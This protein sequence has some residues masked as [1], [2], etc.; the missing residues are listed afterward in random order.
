MEPAWDFFLPPCCQN[1]AN[2][3]SL[4]DP[5][6]FSHR[7]L[8][9]S[10]LIVVMGRRSETFLK[11]PREAAAGSQ[12]LNISPKDKL[13]CCLC[14]QPLKLSTLGMHF[15]RCR[16]NGGG[17][18]RPN[19][20]RK[21]KA[22]EDKVIEAKQSSV[23]PSADD[24]DDDNDD[25]LDLS[26]LDPLKGFVPRPEDEPYEED[27]ES[28]SEDRV[29]RLKQALAESEARVELM[30]RKALKFKGQRNA[31]QRIIS[32]MKT[33]AIATAQKAQ[34]ATADVTA[35]PTAPGIAAAESQH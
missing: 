19:D 18:G 6:H 12:V 13:F 26:G 22:K 3:L 5:Y 35:A 2:R 23:N 9:F 21:P 11:L 28:A 14:G 7:S 33:T 17:K 4:L 15:A 10:C 27:D 32:S 30:G 8:L 1:F 24:C 20:D 29:A 34:T 25:S 31:N 16:N